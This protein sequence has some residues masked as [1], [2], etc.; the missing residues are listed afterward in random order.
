MSRLK[1][2]YVQSFVLLT[3]HLG[4]ILVNNQL[5]VQFFLCMF[6]NCINTTSGICHSVQMTVVQVWMRCRI[7]MSQISRNNDVGRNDEPYR[8]YIQRCASYFTFSHY[9]A[10]TVFIHSLVFSP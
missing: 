8:D 9:L 3:A 4:I 1:S 6:I 2:E 5:D 7:P 10:I